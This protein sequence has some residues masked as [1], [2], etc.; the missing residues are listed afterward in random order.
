MQ[1]NL[2]TLLL[3]NCYLYAAIKVILCGKEN[4]PICK[5]RSCFQFQNEKNARWLMD[6]NGSKE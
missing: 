2:S 1:T 6:D 3:D 4:P 5:P